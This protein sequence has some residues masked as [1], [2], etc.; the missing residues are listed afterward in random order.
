MTGKKLYT[1]SVVGCLAGYGWLAISWLHAGNGGWTACLFKRVFHLPCPACG[2]TRSLL[3]LMQGDV[4][5]AFMLNP[6]GFLLALL[7]VLI[8]LWMLFDLV[9]GRSTYYAFFRKAEAALADKRL[10]VS[11]VILVILNWIWNICKQL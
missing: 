7:L 10:F 5:G 8:P 1:L 2:S 4:Q 6:N 11:L 3:C 9:S